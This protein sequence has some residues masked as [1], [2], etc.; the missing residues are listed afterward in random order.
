MRQTAAVQRQTVAFDLGGVAVGLESRHRG[1]LELAR[2]RYRAFATSQPTQVRVVYRVTGA[3]L[4]SARALAAARDRPL[5][6]RRRGS[7]LHF[8]GAAWNARFDA[9]GGHLEV[10]GPLS[11]YPM[12]Q[13]LRTLWYSRVGRGLIVHAAALARGGHGWLC[14]GPSGSGKTTLAGLFPGAAL[15]DEFAAVHLEAGGARVAGLPFWQGRSGGGTLE[16]IYLLRHG[17]ENHRRRLTAAEAFHRL[18]PQISWPT[19]DSGALLH[20]FTAL[21]DLVARVDAWELAFRPEPDVWR[22]LAAAGRA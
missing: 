5:P 17:R 3:P 15:C 19:F 14:S 21:S 4:P 9:A 2:R 16:A 7:L 8:E 12:D 10:A 20:A 18:R 1:W 11:T 6:P 13:L 22:V